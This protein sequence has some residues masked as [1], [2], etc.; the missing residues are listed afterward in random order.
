M[1]SVKKIMNIALKVVTWLL[2]AFTICMMIFTILSVTTVDRN[3]RSV[4]GMKFY[5]VQ[6]DS[7]SP[8]ENNAHMDV[9]FS[10][11]DIILIKNVKDVKTLK[12]GDIIA[13]LSANS[14]SYGETVTHMIRE[15]KRTEDGKLIGFVTFGTNTGTDDEALVEPEYVI[16]S[17][18]GKLAGVG[19]FFAF[20][21]STPGYIVCILIPFVLL[22]L[23]NGVNVIRLFR[24]YKAEQTAILD[25]EKA[26]IAAER[27]QNE[28]MMRELMA[29]KAQLDKQANAA[30][31][32]DRAQTVDEENSETVT[33]SEENSDNTEQASEN[34]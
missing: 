8:S 29:L 12:E 26:E 10:A 15:V 20:M 17:Y 28:E 13:F 11:G 23:Y 7:M 34:D 24:K 4:F 18:A 22:I 27:K 6:T 32:E 19:N 31:P 21:K 16:G 1:D 25:A 5:I 14:V 33:D 9:H 30:Q 2:V 3:D